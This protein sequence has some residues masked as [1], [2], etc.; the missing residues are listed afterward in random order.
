MNPIMPGEVVSSSSSNDTLSRVGKEAPKVGK[1]V[2]Q[3]INLPAE[4]PLLR[5]YDPNKPYD[6]FKGTNLDVKSIVAPMNGYMSAA[7]DPT[8]LDKL[9]GKLKSVVGLNTQPQRLHIATHTLRIR[10]LSLSALCLSS[11]TGIA[12]GALIA[13]DSITCPSVP[14]K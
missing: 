10:C 2:G 9:Y 5:R 7:G 11:R 4:N 14:K 12:T 6:M 3:P 8:V 13:V 1:S